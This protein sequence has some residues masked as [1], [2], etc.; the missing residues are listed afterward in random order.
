VDFIW[1][2]F[3]CFKVFFEFDAVILSG[4]VVGVKGEE[5][6]LRVNCSCETAIC[7]V[8]FLLDCYL[9]R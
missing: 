4:L 1:R 5:V 8:D 6:P 9:T 2:I 3:N 7:L